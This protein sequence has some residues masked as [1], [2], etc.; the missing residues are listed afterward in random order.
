MHTRIHRQIFDEMCKMVFSLG[1]NKRNRSKQKH[2][3]NFIYHFIEIANIK[4]EINK[5]IFYEIVL[6]TKTS[7]FQSQMICVQRVF[8]VVV[9]GDLF[10]GLFDCKSPNKKCAVSFSYVLFGIQSL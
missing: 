5:F 1:D 10:V 2:N 3:Q 4:S 7:S 6:R 8:V 9:A